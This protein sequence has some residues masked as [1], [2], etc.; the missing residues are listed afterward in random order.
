MR[1]LPCKCRRVARLWTV[2]AA[3]LL[4]G[5][6]PSTSCAAPEPANTPVR[7]MTYNIRNSVNDRN[8]PDNNWPA[9][10]GAL[11][12]VVVG[13]NPDV[14]GFQ[15][16]LPDQREWLEQRFP[17]Y[18]FTGEGRNAD[19]KNGESSPVMYRKSRFDVVK[20]GTFWLSTTPDVP[21][22]KSWKSALPRICSYAVLHDKV[23]GK[24]FC[25]ANTHTDHASEKAREKGMLL[26]IERM[27][28]FGANSPIVFT[29]DHNCLEYEKPAQSVSKILN[30]AL[31]ITET[32]AEGSW[33]TFNYWSYKEHEQ[34]IADALKL[35][36]DKRSIPGRDS[37]S[38]RID[39][40]YVS[41]GTRVLAFRTLATVRP[42]TKLY[43]SDHFPTVADLIID[44]APA[45]PHVV[46]VPGSAKL[47]F[48]TSK[49]PDL[50]Q[51]TEETFA[52]V[53]R[54]WFVKL[55]DLMATDGWEPPKEIL[56]SFVNERLASSTNAA[57]W[58]YAAERRVSLRADWFRMN[59]KGEALG[60]T[61]HELVHIMQNYVVQPGFSR[62]K[63]P[64][65]AS[66]G[67]ADYVRW[68]LFEPESD[69]AAYVR[70]NPYMYRY[71]GS[72]RVTASFFDFVERHYP[73]TMKKLT[74]VLRSCAFDNDAFWPAAT[75]KTAQEL[76]SDW[77]AELIRA[78]R[79]ET[80]LWLQSGLDALS[81]WGDA[82]VP[83]SAR[84]KALAQPK[85]DAGGEITACFIDW[86]DKT[87][88]ND[89]L[90]RLN[91][92]LKEGRYGEALW[93]E[94][95]GKSRLRLGRAWRD[96]MLGLDR[97]KTVYS[98]RDAK[99]ILDW[100]DPFVGTGGTGH[101]TPAATHPFG[102]VQPG[103]DTGTKNWRYCSGYQYTDPKIARFSQLHISGTGCYDAYDVPFMPFTGTVEEQKGDDFWAAYDKKDEKATP[104]YYGVTLDNGTKVE[105]TATP[106]AA[107]YRI[108]FLKDGAK[109]L[110]DPSWGARDDQYIKY[111]DVSKMT[112][113]R[114]SGRLTRKG[115]SPHDYWYSWEVSQAPVSEEVIA[116][117]GDAKVAMTVYSF[118]IPKGGVLYLK[119]SL[120]RNSADAARQNIG[121]EIPGW[122]FD[123]TLTATRAKWRA[124]IGRVQA[125]GTPERLKTFYA[126]IYHTM[127]QPNLI[128]D[129]GETDVYST[130]SC[131]D[132][133]RAAGPL[134]TILA[135]EYV[136][137]FVNSFI[138]HFDRNGWLPIWTLWDHDNQCM[139][140]VHSIPMLVDAYLKGFDGVDWPRAFACVK[141]SITV[142]D[143]MQRRWKAE[144]DILDK[145]GYYPFDVV[146]KN[147]GKEG[148]SRLMEGNYN[149]ACAARLARGL[150]LAE[151]A[152]YFENRSHLWT[153]C[154]DA[155]TGFMRAKDSKG[156]F[157]K[158]FS[159][160]ALFQKD[161]LR[162]NK[163]VYS[164]DYCEG[165][166]WHY[167]W[168][169]M[170][171][172][173]RM[174]ELEGGPEKAAAHLQQMFSANP[175]RGNS[176]G[177]GNES[178]L[179]GQYCQGNEPCHHVIYYFT[180]MG[181]RDL[182]AKYVREIA[183]TLYSSD[184]MGLCGNED[185]GQMSSWYI[186]S[187]MG[188][189]PF[190]PCGTNYVLGEALLPEIAVKT[191]AGK[192]LV[193][194]A[195]TEPGAKSAVKLNG[196]ELSGPYIT[197]QQILGGGKLAF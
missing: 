165:N 64:T 7:V 162:G 166:A 79:E 191:P 111:S 157:R 4:F 52:P 100:V 95:T 167:N 179:L 25:F 145:Y 147:A 187:S 71:N 39:Y 108:T 58:A 15:E 60:A 43:P 149:D 116:T 74:A 81:D 148:V 143:A 94:L 178:G 91:Q 182:A 93:V 104:G 107:I 132:T 153:N 185:C 30:D 48:D 23:T 73:G 47:V 136:P 117:R 54:E 2:G 190:D 18:G 173:A 188:F 122:D 70:K 180:L 83:Q 171:D 159:P 139:I 82:G 184:F 144:Y 10:R 164:L 88:G 141:A 101:T 66:E 16:V 32:P 62:E 115:W 34:S 11:S 3:L 49:A 135:P 123:G 1:G 86:I 114:V 106:H 50:R 127:F 183:E 125:K 133:F 5:F 90:G 97:D 113:N 87:C 160:F 175:Y 137:G 118:D 46:E 99:D 158:P 85:L 102:M 35:P 161:P 63:C 76:E 96:D 44:A 134:Y 6:A 112:N 89:F 196:A 169:Q 177:N 24:K 33:R 45:E 194:T 26:I 109:L 98:T 174:I 193:I 9:R 186:F 181:R 156:N 176:G 110:F 57:A 14:V 59:L 53:M 65:W 80:P 126:A 138:W 19:R 155:V 130:F 72:Y 36:V 92:A 27:K 21:G 22:S 128:S 69:G 192:E 152:A 140:G 105:M 120:S 151:D 121:A 146:K 78:A 55:S 41:P 124:L 163:A 37:D 61:I 170:H 17:D 12:D 197:H 31:Y 119:V 42:G 75:G 189:Y 13:E 20:D 67:E 77:H 8:S 129:Y 68:F 154:Y 195:P 28:D 131:W 51:W 38:K 150:N 40:I 84:N 56:F 168:H 29:G 103:P 142:T 172:A